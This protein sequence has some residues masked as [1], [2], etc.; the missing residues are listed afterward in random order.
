MHGMFLLPTYSVELPVEALNRLAGSTA[1]I[2]D[3]SFEGRVGL[4]TSVAGPWIL[5]CSLGIVPAR[6]IT[7]S[8]RTS[9]LLE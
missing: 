6:T 1:T 2:R 8:T 9:Y 3:P 5:R 4:S 7:N